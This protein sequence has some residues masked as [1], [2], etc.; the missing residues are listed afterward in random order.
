M[1]GAITDSFEPEHQA[2]DLDAPYGSTVYAA[3]DGMVRYANW[4]EDGLGYTVIIDHGD[5][6]ETLYVHL[7]GALV[8]AGTFVA[9][10]DAVGEVGTTSAGHSSGPHMH[11]EVRLNGQPVNPVDY[12]PAGQPK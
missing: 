4:G 2:I 12:L 11:F 6:L 7:K 10:G 9:R 1:V 8:Q 3:A 5:G